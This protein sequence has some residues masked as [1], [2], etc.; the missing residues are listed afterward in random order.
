MQC[1]SVDYTAISI[2]VRVY[3][4]RVSMKFTATK[5]ECRIG[6]TIMYPLQLVVHEFNFWGE[7]H[8]KSKLFT[9]RPRENGGTGEKNKTSVT[10][11]GVIWL[12]LVKL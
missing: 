11:E 7:G 6:L 8:T 4:Q 1:Q 5:N 3:I 2:I 10:A 9:T 12:V